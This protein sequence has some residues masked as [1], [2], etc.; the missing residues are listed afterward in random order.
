[1][2][3]TDVTPLVSMVCVT[4]NRAKYLPMAI[5]CFEQQTYPNLELIIVDDGTEQIELP[6]DSR[7]RYIRLNERATTGAK[8]NIGAAVARGEIIASLDD[9][10]WSSPHRI[11]DQVQRLVRSN[12]AVTGYNETIRYDEQTGRVYKN[13]AAYPFHASGTSQCYLKKWWEENPFPDVNCGE[14]TEFSRV[15]IMSDQLVTVPLGKMIVARKHSTNT[16]PAPLQGLKEVSTAEISPEFFSALK[17]L[18]PTPEYMVHTHDCTSLCRAETQL[19]FEVKAYGVTRPRILIGI[20][21]CHRDRDNGAQQAQRD[22]WLQDTFDRHV[23]YRFFLGRPK[24]DS[25]QDE[26]FLDADDSYGALSFKTQE[27]CRWALVNGY[28]WLY[29]TDTDTLV[30]VKNLL[31]SGFEMYDYMGSENEDY[32]PTAYRKRR[33]SFPG[34][35]IQFASGGAGY[36][37]SRRAMQAVID[38]TDAQYALQAEDVFVAI[39]LSGAGIKPTW[40]SQM[41]WRPGR[42]L[43]FSTISYH[44]SSVLQKK[45]EPQLMYEYY[46]RLKCARS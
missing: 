5:R 14:D 1:M 13:I 27:M 40:C 10:D 22:T 44:L 32:T 16:S 4:Y 7:I 46:E 26:V 18:A 42:E 33:G 34:S 41:E 30:C 12:K 25:S 36:W 2:K 35:R 8:R 19:Y 37:L 20:E 45:Y 6:A 23:D 39:A 38:S 29:K 24:S 31:K 9:D 15:A 11:E 43:G 21:S 28:E 3:G 17:G